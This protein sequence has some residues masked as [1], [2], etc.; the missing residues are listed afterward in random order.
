MERHDLGPFIRGHQRVPPFLA[1]GKA[2]VEIGISLGEVRSAGGR[3]L[4]QLVADRLRNTPPVAR[5]EPVVRIA[6]RM[7][8]PHR[9][10]DLPCRNF[11]NFHIQR[12]I[13]IPI[14]PRLNLAVAAARQQRWEPPNLQLASNDDQDIGLAHRENE[15]RFRIDK[16]RVLISARQR[17]HRHPVAADLAGQRSKIFGCRDDV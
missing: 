9:A 15:A 14:G 11:Q 12:C 10:R 13:Q 3:E 7:N 8:V 16:V 17:R 4:A 5:L 6:E 1:G 2:T